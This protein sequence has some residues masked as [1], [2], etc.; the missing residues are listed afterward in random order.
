LKIL[1]YVVA[2]FIASLNAYL[3]IRVVGSWIA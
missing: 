1:A 3:L 2:V